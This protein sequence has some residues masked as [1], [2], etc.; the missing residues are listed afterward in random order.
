[1]RKSRFF[2]R[3]AYISVD[4]LKRKSGIAALEKSIKDLEHQ[5]SLSRQNT[6]EYKTLS[7]NYS[8]ATAHFAALDGYAF[9]ARA[10][11]VLKGFGFKESDF[12]QNCDLFSI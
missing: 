3:D 10:K 6:S 12:T 11:Q 9:E 2:Q 5:I 8:D 1:M 4:F 7:Q